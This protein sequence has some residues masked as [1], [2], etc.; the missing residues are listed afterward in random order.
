MSLKV[1]KESL[2][3]IVIGLFGYIAYNY[4]F[5]SV[6]DYQLVLLWLIFATAYLLC[7]A[8]KAT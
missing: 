2:A 8:P 7:L 4:V 3:V 6:W 5:K 1:L